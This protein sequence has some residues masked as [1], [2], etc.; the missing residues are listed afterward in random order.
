M[1]QTKA[2]G[3]LTL[4]GAPVGDHHFHVDCPGQNEVTVFLSL[5]PGER[6]KID[7]NAIRAKSLRFATPLQAAEARLRL[8]R[9]VERGIRSRSRGQFDEA[10]K[11]LREAIQLDPNNPDL[12]RELGVTFLINHDRLAHCC[13][14]SKNS[15]LDEL[16]KNLVGDQE[17]A[18]RQPEA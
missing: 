3:Q 11:L 10:V 16:L 15:N 2:A 6:A 13:G 18:R 1:G 17:R 4:R 8:R 12:H 14:L 9:I 5:H 7:V